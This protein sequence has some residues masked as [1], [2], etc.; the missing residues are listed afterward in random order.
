M[1]SFAVLASAFLVPLLV[2]LLP[3]LLATT[4]SA[5]RNKGR[6]KVE[7]EAFFCAVV[8]LKRFIKA[9]VCYMYAPSGPLYEKARARF[10]KAAK[11]T[12][13]C[14]S[15]NLNEIRNCSNKLTTYFEGMEEQTEEYKQR[16]NR[17]ME[18][19][20][21]NEM[22]QCELVVGTTLFG[23]LVQPFTTDAD[24]NAEHPHQEETRSEDSTARNNNN[25][26][27]SNSNSN[28][29][30]DGETKGETKEE[31]TVATFKDQGNNCVKRAEFEQALKYYVQAINVS[32]HT[33]STI[34][35][36]YANCGYCY[37]QLRMYQKAIEMCNVS[38]L[39]N[40]SYS[41]AHAR[42][43]FAKLQIGDVQGGIISL[44]KSLELYPNNP[45]V[46]KQLYDVYRMVEMMENPELFMEE[47]EEMKLEMRMQQAT[48]TTTTAA[49]TNND[50]ELAM[51]LQT[52]ENIR[53]R[54]A[55]A[56]SNSHRT[57]GSRQHVRSNFYILQHLVKFF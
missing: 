54:Q 57:R 18:N 14:H 8:R 29:H 5:T 19:Q 16:Y 44:E 31:A 22:A 48:T 26:N 53:G 17:M 23:P 52:E 30:D 11:E 49:D 43:G 32:T 46:Q 35:I 50:L 39:L 47:I 42:L 20:I 56:Y 3:T 41:K 6:Q 9:Y 10:A 34:Y 40:D 7:V 15:T 4:A 37:I 25:N 1:S 24:A 13:S 27:N 55:H 12:Q 45:S 2:P 51:R 38:I 36:V 21:R 33:D 28:N